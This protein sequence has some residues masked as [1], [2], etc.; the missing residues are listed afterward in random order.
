[1]TL[2]DS[3]ADI[4]RRLDW[5]ACTLSGEGIECSEV[6]L[7]ASELNEIR[8]DIERKTSAARPALV[9]IR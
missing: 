5:V 9:V 2:P 1:M 7:A 4:G 6:A 3:L 8:L